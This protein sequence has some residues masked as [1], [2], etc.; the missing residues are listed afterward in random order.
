MI[1]ENL[2]IQFRDLS[3]NETI[4]GMW[5]CY[6]SRLTT[7]YIISNFNARF[8]RNIDL[9]RN[10]DASYKYNKYIYVEHKDI[11]YATTIFSGNLNSCAMLKD[12]Y[13]YVLLEKKL[14]DDFGWNFSYWWINPHNKASSSVYIVLEQKLV[15]TNYDEF[16]WSEFIWLI[17][18]WIVEK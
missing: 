7:I 8:K 9:V 13:I 14:T 10:P 3:S 16:I 4:L 5:I 18:F 12:S 11:E 2:E 1:K 6:A 17:F 15:I